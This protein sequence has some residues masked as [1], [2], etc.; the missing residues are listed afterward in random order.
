MAQT[1]SVSASGMISIETHDI[2]TREYDT[3]TNMSRVAEWESVYYA[4]LDLMSRWGR[5]QSSAP[6]DDYLVID[7]DWGGMTQKIEIVNPK[8]PIEDIS[9]A[10]QALLAAKFKSWNVIVVFSDGTDR[11]GLRLY[12]DKVVRES[13]DLDPNMQ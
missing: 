9:K 2:D 4:L 10:I 12:P 1:P 5:D 13:E 3:M 6:P 7:D 11:E 8:L